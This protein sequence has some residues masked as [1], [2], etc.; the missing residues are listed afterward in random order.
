ERAALHHQAAA[1]GWLKGRSTAP[2]PLPPS[3]LQAL[4]ALAAELRFDQDEVLCRQAAAHLI[5]AVGAEPPQFPLAAAA[6]DL[7]DSIRSALPRSLLEAIAEGSLPLTERWSLARAWCATG[8]TE[9]GAA[10][11]DQLIDEAAAELL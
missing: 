2:A 8:S 4:A 7:A 6:L 5:D 1:L 3:W 10:E 9:V 11:R